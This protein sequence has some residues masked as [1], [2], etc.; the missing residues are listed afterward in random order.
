[1][2]QRLEK[3]LTI[4]GAYPKDGED[5]SRFLGEELDVICEQ[6]AD[7]LMFGDGTPIELKLSE[8]VATLFGVQRLLSIAEKNGANIP[9]LKDMFLIELEQLYTKSREF[10]YYSK[11]RMEAEGLEVEVKEGEWE[12]EE[13]FFLKNSTGEVTCLENH[14]GQEPFLAMEKWQKE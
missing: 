2:N 8:L 9:L 6:M 14:V 5:L 7:S 4:L 12:G 3:A 1:M 10:A 11:G 13:Y